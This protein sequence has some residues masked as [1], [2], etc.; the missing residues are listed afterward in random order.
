[1]M[2]NLAGRKVLAR[3][4]QKTIQRSAMLGALPMRG[5]YKDDVLMERVQGEYHADPMMVAER[6]VRLLALHDNVSDPSA[7]TL[8]CSFSDIGL[9]A[10]DMCEVFIALEHD[11]DLDIDEDDCERM[12]TIN[13][14]V[15]F[16][17][18]NP[19]TK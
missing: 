12:S 6:V 8:N 9:N 2:L 11:F 18:K 17:A 19:N 16:L 1:M 7:I 5:Y 15:E 4:G 13:D 10:L 3:I 14:L